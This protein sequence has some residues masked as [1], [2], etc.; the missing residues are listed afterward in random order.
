MNIAFY[1]DVHVPGPITAGLRKRDVE[2]VVCNPS[3]TE[4]SQS[5]GRPIAFGHNSWGAYIAV[6]YEEVGNDVVYPVT[7]FELKEE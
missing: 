3:K 1:M 4:V 7:A 5:S 2:E 6:V